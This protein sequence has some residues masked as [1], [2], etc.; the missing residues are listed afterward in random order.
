MRLSTPLNIRLPLKRVVK[1]QHS[2]LL[3]LIISD[4]EKSLNDRHQADLGHHRAAPHLLLLR[5][6]WDGKLQGCE[7]HQL[8]FVSFKSSKVS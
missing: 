1:E 2:S 8:L 3:G 5:H 7:A 6:H 4:E